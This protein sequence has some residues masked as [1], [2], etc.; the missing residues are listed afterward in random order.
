[1]VQLINENRTA[2]IRLTTGLTNTLEKIS[3]Q[4]M[5]D[6]RRN[7]GSWWLPQGKLVEILQPGNYAKR[8]IHLLIHVEAILRLCSV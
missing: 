8:G 5:Q 4:A 3:R 2:S 1:M 6:Q 7:L